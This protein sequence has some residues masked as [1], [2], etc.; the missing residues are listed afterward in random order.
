[1]NNFNGLREILTNKFWDMDA[2]SIR[3]YRDLFER[4]RSMHIPLV[5]EPEKDFRPAFLSSRNGFS[6]ALYVGDAEYIRWRHELDEND[7][8]ISLVWVDGPITRNGGACSH[9]SKQ[10]RDCVMQ[11]ADIEQTIGHIFIIDSDGGSSASKYDFKYAIDYLHSKGQ[12]AI[13]L[14]DGMACSA[15]YALACLCDEIYFMDGKNWVGCIGTMAAFTIQIP[16][17]EDERSH[18]RYVELYS[19]YSSMKNDDFRK[20]QDGDYSEIISEL[21]R[22]ASD[23]IDMVKSGR[24]NVTDEQLAGVTYKAEDV[25]GTLVDGQGTLDSCVNR[26]LELNAIPSAGQDTEPEQPMED[27]ESSEE[28]DDDDDKKR[29]KCGEDDESPEDDENKKKRCG[30]TED[31][32]ADMNNQ[33]RNTMKEYN[34]IKNACGAPALESDKEDHLFLHREYC[35]TLE[36]YIERAEQN[37]SVLAAKMEEI[38][39]LSASIDQLKSEHQEAVD[40]LN[41]EHQE[42]V[43]AKDV[44]IASLKSQVD[45]AAEDLREKN[46]E[47]E[48]LADEPVQAP[49]PKQSPETD[50]ADAGKKQTED[51]RVCKPGMTAKERREALAKR[52]EELRRQIYG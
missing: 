5:M 51:W 6:E 44:E 22:S 47:I 20:A 31:G 17:T 28:P 11:A 42:A 24:P 33:N 35:E 48:Q 40:K 37:E 12:K 52:N 3:E 50:G 36:K 30:D 41:A 45:K 34:H 26:I 1:M 25:V 14:I 39:K 18:D 21:N 27:D 10:I 19:D 49:T 43:N 15:A 9:G 4:N 38:S 8:L 23:F 2:D 46:Q 16:F 29:K 7:R 13:A 32:N